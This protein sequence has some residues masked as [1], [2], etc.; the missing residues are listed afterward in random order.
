MKN[1]K[2]ALITGAA[3]GI[4]RSIAIKLAQNGYNLVLSYNTSELRAQTL[5][6]ELEEKYNRDILLVKCDVSKEEDIINMINKTKEKFEHVDVLV[7][8]A[9][10]AQDNYIDDK[11][12]EEFMKVLEVN[13]V[14]P[15]LMIKK[16]KEIM[17]NGLIINISSTDSE[18][19]YSEIS[20]DYCASKAGLNSLT[21]VTAKALKNIKVIAILLPWVETESVLEMDP[22]Y[23]KS[24]LERTKQKKMLLPIEVADQIFKIINNKEIKSGDIIRMVIE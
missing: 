11:T 23:L 19:T 12:K 15:F 1:N 3:K 7:N 22:E 6:K 24:E 2:V 5:K 4:G 9:A 13:L 10:T 21:K 17:E 14:G 18:D 20:I 8:N 16:S